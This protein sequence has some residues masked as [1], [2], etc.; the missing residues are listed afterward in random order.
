MTF[1]EKIAALESDI[2]EMQVM[3]KVTERL[4]DRNNEQGEGLGMLIAIDVLLR[5][6]IVHYEEEIA[7][8]KGAAA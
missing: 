6:A 8:L 2:T 1:A 7:T 5:Q 3:L 4:S